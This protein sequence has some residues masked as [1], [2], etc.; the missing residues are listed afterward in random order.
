[1]HVSVTTPGLRILQQCYHTAS[2]LYSTAFCGGC[3]LCT[4]MFTLLSERCNYK[5]TRTVT[6]H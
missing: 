1:M 5:Q 2:S 3:F 6:L 4:N